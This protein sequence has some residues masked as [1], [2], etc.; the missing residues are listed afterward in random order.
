MINPEAGIAFKVLDAHVETASA[1]VLISAMH[2]AKG[3][4]VVVMACDD[5]IIPLQERIETVGDDADLQEI[6]DTER[7]LLLRRLYSRSGSS[8]G[9]RCCPGIRISGRLRKGRPRSARTW[10]N[11]SGAGVDTPAPADGVTRSACLVLAGGRLRNASSGPALARPPRQ[12]KHTTSRPRQTCSTGRDRVSIQ[13]RRIADETAARAQQPAI[14]VVGFLG[15][16]PLGANKA[17]RASPRRATSAP[18]GWGLLSAGNSGDTV[19]RPAPP[20]RS[21]SSEPRAD[22]AGRSR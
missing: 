17:P 6:Y 20:A 3:R 12:G 21:T 11:Q 10:M 18:T 4:A 16:G 9:L 8:A 13:Q 2:L 1:Y 19:K 15:I 5:E 7:H 14:P 22:Q